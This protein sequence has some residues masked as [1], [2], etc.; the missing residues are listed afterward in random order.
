MKSHQQ[1]QRGFAMIIVIVVVVVVL[2]GGVGYVAWNNFGKQ[3]VAEVAGSVASESANQECQKK[4]DKDLCKFLSNWKVSEKYRITSVN[5]G[6]KSVIEIDG[7]KNHMVT[8]GQAA[9]DVITI[10]KTTYTKAGSGVWYKQTIKTPEQDV[11]KDT[12]VE[13]KEPADDKAAPEDKTTYKSL[14]KEACG[15]LQ[16]FKYEIVDPANAKSKEF[17][18][19][20]DKEYKLRKTT[21]ES[22]D[23]NSEQTFEYDNVSVNVPSP[24]K[25]LAADEYLMPGT[26]E[27]T[28]L[29]TAASA[30]EQQ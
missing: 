11:A 20:D 14:G 16:C 12:K 29:P 26:A 4:N 6:D 21:T 1:D 2:L 5:G 17:I 25:E 13:F 23:G 9:Y 19:F 7:N 8:S 28:K 15:S 10:D 3:K 18:W 27:P 24:V 22:P 30:M